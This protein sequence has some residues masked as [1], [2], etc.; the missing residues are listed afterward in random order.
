MPRAL[1][2][3]AL[4][5]LLRR[6]GII[7]P[8]TVASFDRRVPALWN[9]ATHNESPIDFINWWASWPAEQ[10]RGHMISDRTHFWRSRAKGHSVDRGFVTYPDGLLL[11][12]TARIMRPDEVTHEHALQFMEV[13]VEEFEV[14]KTTPY[15]RHRLKS[16]FKYLYSMFVSN[17]RI[18]IH[19]MDIGRREIGQPSD[20]FVLFRIIDQASHQA[21]EYSELVDNHLASTP[22]ETQKYSR[23]VTEAY[24]V[25]DRA[26]G[27]LIE[28]FGEG[29]VVVISDHGF[30]LLR[31][32]KRGAAY[33][34]AGPSAPNG[35]FIGAGPAFRTGRVEGLGIY[36]M[37]PLFLAL[38]GWPVAQDFVEG[39]PKRVFS[40]DFLERH[41]VEWTDS[42]GTM[43][44]SLPQQGPIVADKEMIERLRA[45]GYLD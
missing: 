4:E 42:Y 27:R 8:S 13:S 28:D 12:L 37:M 44:V 15:R 16:E 1:G 19:L 29:N 21:L 40:E 20:L 11:D 35:I 36:D 45:L 23:V 31:T 41:P 10:I 22:A 2:A 5:R 26:V 6:W 7:A 3:G 17:L 38:K 24:R 34:H 43:V 32:R 39:V 25:A 14:M 33:D 18:A 30:R 9:I